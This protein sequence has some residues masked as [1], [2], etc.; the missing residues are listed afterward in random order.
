MAT[1]Y[2]Q[3]T[4]VDRQTCI[5]TSKITCGVEDRPYFLND[6]SNT[7]PNRIPDPY[8]IPKPNPNHIPTMLPSGTGQ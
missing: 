1:N 2:S 5:L 6:N 7:N 8:P 3:F 4:S